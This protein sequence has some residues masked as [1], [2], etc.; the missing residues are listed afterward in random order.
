MSRCVNS[1]ISKL[2]TETGL[3]C[4]SSFDSAL[5]ITS[6]S[7]QP[8]IPA[9]LFGGLLYIFTLFL[10]MHQTF[11]VSV[12]DVQRGDEELV[13]VLLLIAGQVTSVRP[14]QVQ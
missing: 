9:T 12:Q 4:L 14:H 3:L 1:H 6:P 5:P 7:P 10:R 2:R 13:C 11:T 8:Q